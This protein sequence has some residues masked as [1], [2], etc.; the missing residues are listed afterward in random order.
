[1]RLSRPTSDG[2]RF[3]LNSF[4]ADRTRGVPV[5]MEPSEEWSA[6]H[7]MN[8][9]LRGLPVEEADPYVFKFV[10]GLSS[11]SM[12]KLLYTVWGSLTT[13]TSTFVNTVA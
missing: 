9:M 11:R 4:N 2:G 1:M 7:S 13:S 10:G 12:G 8:A 6:I 5:K 3:M